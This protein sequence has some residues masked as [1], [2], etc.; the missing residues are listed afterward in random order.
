MNRVDQG[1]SPEDPLV[2]AEVPDPKAADRPPNPPAVDRA[3]FD[4]GGAKDRS[5]GAMGENAAETPDGAPAPELP[6]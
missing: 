6:R 2:P 5:G 3:G 1:S 4:L